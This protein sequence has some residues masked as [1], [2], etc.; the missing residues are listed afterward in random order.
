ME[1]NR[2]TI[3]VISVIVMA[4]LLIVLFLP[5]GVV[6]PLA[7]VL[8]VPAAVAACLFIKK[9][10]ALSLTSGTVLLLMIVIGTL[11][12]MGY[13]VSGLFVGFTKTGYG[14]HDYIILSYTLPIGIIIV[15]TELIRYVLCAQKIRSATFFAYFICLLGDLV[16]QSPLSG[17]TI[18]SNFIDL[19]GLALFPGLLFNAL[20]NYLS[21]RYGWK[22]ILVFRLLTTWVFYLIPYGSAIS[23]SLLA[24]INILLPIGIYCFIDFLFEKKR[25]YARKKQSRFSRTTSYILTVVTLVGMLGIVMLI[26]NHFYYGAYVIATESMTGELNKGD[27]AIS[28][29]YEGQLIKEGQVIAF[30]KSKAVIIHRVVDIQVINGTTR[31]ITKGDANEDIDSGYVVNSQ[32]V[33]LVD[34][35]V[36]FLGYPTIWM[37][38]LF[39]H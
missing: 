11:Y 28:T 29:R 15:C 17:V 1:T 23:D 13:Y 16:I 14:L 21:L 20:Y 8:L 39:E 31:Y 12:V 4:V 6:R 33:A 10:V 25:R 27:V 37:R 22:P 30:K 7:A 26:S 24:F 5:V 35:K 38:N 36:P 3:H 19:L 32:I 34:L 18:Y 2:K 9:R